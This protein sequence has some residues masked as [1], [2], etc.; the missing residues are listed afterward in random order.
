MHDSERPLFIFVFY[1]ASGVRDAE[2]EK[3]EKV[4]EWAK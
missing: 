3:E 1:A 4:R 2:E